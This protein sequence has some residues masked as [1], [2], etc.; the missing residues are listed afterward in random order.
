MAAIGALLGLDCVLLL[1]NAFHGVSVPRKYRAQ[2]TTRHDCKVGMSITSCRSLL[3]FN[4]MFYT[5]GRRLR[6]SG[7]I[8]VELLVDS[9]PLEES[10]GSN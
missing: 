7:E 10:Q 5:R 4:K 1:A 9:R 8:Q 3:E 6:T 2:F